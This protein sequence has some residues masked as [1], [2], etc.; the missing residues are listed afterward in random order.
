[1]YNCC[2]FS[3]V[4]KIT[5]FYITKYININSNPNH[6]FLSTPLYLP[7]CDSKIN[8][9]RATCVLAASVLSYSI[10]SLINYSPCYYL[11]TALLINHRKGLWWRCWGCGHWLRSWI[12]GVYCPPEDHSWRN[13]DRL[14][15]TLGSG[16]LPTDSPFLSERPHERN[17]GS[18]VQRSE[19]L[20]P[21]I[22]HKWGPTI[23]LLRSNSAATV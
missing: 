1:M 6:K 13:S 19:T 2:N 11:F 20:R 22:S 23:P 5:T 12:P 18:E 4:T 9:L 21:F 10:F 7:S 14:E 17:R 8:W 3:F 15:W 16:R